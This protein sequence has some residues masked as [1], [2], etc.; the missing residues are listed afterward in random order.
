MTETM[1]IER[2]AVE[3]KPVDSVITLR[4][5]HKQDDELIQTLDAL[6]TYV[7]RSELLR[8]ALREYLKARSF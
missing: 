2:A 1:R 5:R 6:P 3:R 8:E 4:L 7:N